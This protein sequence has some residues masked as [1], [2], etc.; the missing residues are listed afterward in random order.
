MQHPKLCQKPSVL[1]SPT[2]T[3]PLSNRCMFIGTKCP[4]R[5]HGLHQGQAERSQE[6]LQQQIAFVRQSRQCRIYP[7]LLT[8]C[9]HNDNLRETLDSWTSCIGCI[10][11][12]GEFYA[13]MSYVYRSHQLYIPRRTFVI[14]DDMVLLRILAASALSITPP[15]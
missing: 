8:C 10:N 13:S 3:K 5:N 7:V 4:A 9:C 15:I 1:L 6:E 14:T 12:H 2:A 11:L